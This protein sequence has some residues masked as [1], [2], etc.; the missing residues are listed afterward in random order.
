[1][2]LRQDIA[3]EPPP[4]G[5]EKILTDRFIGRLIQQRTPDAN[6]TLCKIA[7]R[8][9]ENGWTAQAELAGWIAMT[10]RKL[11][12]SGTPFPRPRGARQHYAF[13]AAY[14]SK[15]TEAGTELAAAKERAQKKFNASRQTVN[16]ALR[17]FDMDCIYRD[18]LLEELRE[19]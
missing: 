7:S 1:M 14:V 11:A 2:P 6:V 5:V 10:M 4:L 16:R 19:R 13:I 18:A 12:V 17:M 9:M 15:L 3:A 8:Y